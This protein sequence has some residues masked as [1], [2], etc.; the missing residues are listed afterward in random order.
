MSRTKE[1]KMENGRTEEIL[2]KLFLYISEAVNDDKETYRVLRH[3]IGL[4]PQ[5]VLDTEVNGLEAFAEAEGAR[6]RGD[7]ADDSHEPRSFDKTAESRNKANETKRI[8]PVRK[9]CF[10]DSERYKTLISVGEPIDMPAFLLPLH[11][12]YEFPDYCGMTYVENWYVFETEEEACACTEKQWD[13]IAEPGDEPYYNF[14]ELTS[15]WKEAT[16]YESFDSLEEG[17]C[18]ENGGSEEKA[19]MRI[20]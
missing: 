4:T 12:S 19:G 3:S 18:A 20:E 7:M 11:E 6:H 16:R 13:A 8:Y 1:A 17:Q 15:E 5:E 14:P 2:G 9:M 10:N